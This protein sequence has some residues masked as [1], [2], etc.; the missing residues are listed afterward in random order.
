MSHTELHVLSE[1]REAG[2]LILEKQGLQWCRLLGVDFE[3]F[4]CMKYSNEAPCPRN[5]GGT[6]L[7]MLHSMLKHQRET[8]FWQKL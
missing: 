8:E 5:D 6:F 7:I 4:G 3:G 2:C 1:N